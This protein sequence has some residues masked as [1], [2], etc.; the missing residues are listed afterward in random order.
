M[1]FTGGA[2]CWNGPA[3]SLTVTLLCGDTE[4][5]FKVEEPARCEYVA[6]M[7]TPAV[8]SAQHL[9][10]IKAKAASLGLSHDELR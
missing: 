9:L 3:R 5:L 1:L 8:C 10:T 7:T 4:A 6:E 2:T